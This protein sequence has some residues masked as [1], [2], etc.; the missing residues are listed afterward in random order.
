MRRSL[1][2]MTNILKLIV[3]LNPLKVG[4]VEAIFSWGCQF[5][6]FSPYIFEEE[7]I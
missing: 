5:G 7:L 3:D 1:Q 2:Q 4:I 6:H